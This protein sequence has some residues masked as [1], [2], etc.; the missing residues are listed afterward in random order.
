MG[1]NRCGD[2]TVVHWLCPECFFTFIALQVHE[3]AASWT[4][5][6]ATCESEGANLAS[7]HT[8]AENSVIKL[9]ASTLGRNLWIG[10][11]D[12]QASLSCL[13]YILLDVLTENTYDLYFN[14]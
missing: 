3:T 1:Q 9:A 13:K 7:I 4:N 8:E 6:Q 14:V 11:R 5:A 10:G 2:F 12:V